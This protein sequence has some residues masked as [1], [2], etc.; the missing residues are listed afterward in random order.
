MELVHH[1]QP[2]AQENACQEIL[3]QHEVNAGMRLLAGTSH[4]PDDLPTGITDTFQ[5]DMKQE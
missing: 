2:N 1:A 3:G 4:L 5:E